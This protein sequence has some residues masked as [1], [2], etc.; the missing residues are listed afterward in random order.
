M[1]AGTRALPRKSLAVRSQHRFWRVRHN[2][3]QE[4]SSS[5][6]SDVHAMKAIVVSLLA[7]AAAIW[8]YVVYQAAEFLWILY[9]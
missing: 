4:R 6:E 3:V 9:G 1:H 8:S 5:G 2:C 7:V